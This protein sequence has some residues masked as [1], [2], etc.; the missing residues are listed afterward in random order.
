MSDYLNALARRRAKPAAAP[1]ADTTRERARAHELLRILRGAEAL[2]YVV[3]PVS[4]VVL[5]QDEHPDLKAWA[6]W[7]RPLYPAWAIPS[8]LV[9][10]LW[11][12]RPDRGWQRVVIAPHEPPR[13]RQRRD[14]HRTQG[15]GW[16][17]GI[18]RAGADGI[19][20]GPLTEP[21]PDEP[22]AVVALTMPSD[23]ARNRIV[24]N[25]GA[26]KRKS[27]R[28]REPTQDQ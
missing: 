3:G 19:W 24:V 2:H 27:A 5:P 1:V 14:D 25:G 4:A 17:Q 8:T 9:A 18:G 13:L 11:R 22:L 23:D 12:G 7:L 28:W 10:E 26:V 20:K 15:P 6:A 16:W 21:L